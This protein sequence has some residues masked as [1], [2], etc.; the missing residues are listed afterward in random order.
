MRYLH[1]ARIQAEP[2]AGVRAVCDCGFVGTLYYD[3]DLAW[4][5]ALEHELQNME[6]SK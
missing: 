4:N 6:G 5:Q 2:F 1:V 3:S